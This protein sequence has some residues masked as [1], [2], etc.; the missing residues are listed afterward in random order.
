MPENSPSDHWD[1]LASELGT[2]PPEADTAKQ[3]EPI[4]Q[5]KR[6]AKKSPPTRK[7]A[8]ADWGA[9]ASSLGVTVEA[10]AEPPEEATAKTE[11]EAAS[12]IEQ[13]VSEI[14]VEF[15]E[16]A[17]EQ[18]DEPDESGES[19]AEVEEAAAESRSEPA[20]VPR[21]QPPSPAQTALDALFEGP[22]LPRDA[23]AAEK[24]AAPEE[25]LPVAEAPV[26][27]EAEITSETA[28]EKSEKSG[29]RRRRRRR[30]K[31]KDADHIASEDATAEEEADASAEDLAPD[32]VAE[33]ED[34]EKLEEHGRSKRRRK[35]RGSS[36]KRKKDEP[37]A[38]AGDALGEEA[39]EG[40]DSSDEDQAALSK[41]SKQKP[42]H[43]AIPTWQEAIGVIIAGNTERRKKNGGGSGRGRGRGRGKGR[44]SAEGRKKSSS[45]RSKKGS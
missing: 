26:E 3:P 40:D 42:S 1:L 29:T 44:G 7:P 37:V 30:R 6:A 33:A 2:P 41:P 16:E 18:L 31:P 17:Q 13:R 11:A 43:R 5:T 22:A 4:A 24:P 28:E 27:G 14:D 36:R 32:V 21:A 15:I 12:V 19:V 20:D 25:V 10:E 23:F 8:E 39:A 35:R 38:A 45:G 9:I 34:S